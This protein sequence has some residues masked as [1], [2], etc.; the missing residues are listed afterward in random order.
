MSGDI[1]NIPIS[2]ST[3][4]KIILLSEK[5]YFLFSQLHHFYRILRTSVPDSQKLRGFFFFT[6]EF[7]S[8]Q[9]LNFGILVSLV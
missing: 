4:S 8:I 2:I 9:A 6:S 7:N 5:C 1:L 3:F